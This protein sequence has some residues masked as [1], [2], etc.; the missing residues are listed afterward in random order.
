[1]KHLAFAALLAMAPLHAVAG[2]QE[3]VQAV[4]E[5]F[6]RDFTAGDVGAI[7]RHFAPEAISEARS[8]AS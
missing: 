6:L 2:P 4:F 7:S 3:D 5:N 8:R 1:M